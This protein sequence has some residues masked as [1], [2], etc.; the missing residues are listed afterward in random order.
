MHVLIKHSWFAAFMGLVAFYFAIPKLQTG[1]SHYMIATADLFLRTGSLDMRPLA[2]ADKGVSLPDNYQFVVAAPLSR[3]RLSRR[4][5][6]RA[7]SP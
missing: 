5:R 2:R 3:P 4:R 7:S 6:R 1:D